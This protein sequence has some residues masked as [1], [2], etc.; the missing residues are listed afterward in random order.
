VNTRTISVF[1]VHASKVEQGEEAGLPLSSQGRMDT[2]HD[3]L[4]WSFKTEVLLI[5]SYIIYDF[6]YN[7]QGVLY[8]LYLIALEFLDFFSVAEPF[9][10]FSIPFL[11][12][13]KLTLY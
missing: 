10:F 5:L 8:V 4:Q 13:T 7:Y 3:P 2:H 6:L 9:P 12:F 1:V 11:Y